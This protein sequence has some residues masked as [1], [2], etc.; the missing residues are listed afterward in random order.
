MFEEVCTIVC[1]ADDLAAAKAWWTR[2]WVIGNPQ[3]PGSGPRSLGQHQRRD[4]AASERLHTGGA[5]AQPPDLRGLS[6]SDDRGY[7]GHR[8]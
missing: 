4:A 7:G 6:D 5:C 1:P 2:C 8:A 3:S